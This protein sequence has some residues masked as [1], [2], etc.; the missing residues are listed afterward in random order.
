[1]TPPTSRSKRYSRRCQSKKA[2][3]IISDGQDKATHPLREELRKPGQGSGRTNLRDRHNDP[4]PSF[5]G[6]LAG[7]V[8]EEIAQ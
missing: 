2:L 7:S 5:G 6:L 3:L 4:P 1:M 8:L